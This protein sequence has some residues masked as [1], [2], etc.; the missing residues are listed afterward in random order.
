[1]YPLLLCSILVLTIVIERSY[2]FLRLKKSPKKLLTKIKILIE[3][4]NFREAANLARVNNSPVLK[5]IKIGINNHQKSAREREKILTRIGSKELRKM[6][7][8]LRGLG[9]ISHIAPL[10]GLLGTVTGIIKAFMKIYELGGNIDPIVLA[11]GISQALITTAVG[12]TVAIPASIFYQYFE[13]KID[14]HYNNMTE[15][16]QLLTEWLNEK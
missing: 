8:Y 15:K 5:L 1:M 14:H 9:I 6:S 16:T 7:K 10:I 13:G 3:Q 12:L 2:F 4:G 11:G